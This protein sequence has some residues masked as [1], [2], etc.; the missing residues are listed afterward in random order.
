MR[1]QTTHYYSRRVDKRYGN[2]VAMTVLREMYLHRP[3]ARRA[4]LSAER[5][6]KTGRESAK[7]NFYS[8]AE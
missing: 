6:E 3:C 7:R 4:K 2:A 1:Q 5:R 8:A